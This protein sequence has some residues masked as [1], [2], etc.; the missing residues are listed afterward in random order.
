M[1]RKIKCW[2]PRPCQF[3]YE[4]MNIVKTLGR[5]DEFFVFFCS[6]CLKIYAGSSLLFRGLTF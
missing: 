1:S 2:N 5:V 4:P 6:K 3:F